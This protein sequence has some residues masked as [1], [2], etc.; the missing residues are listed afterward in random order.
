MIFFPRDVFSKTVASKNAAVFYCKYFVQ[1]SI[2]I[3]I[4]TVTQNAWSSN[5]AH[6]KLH[7]ST[8]K[9]NR[10]NHSIEVDSLVFKNMAPSPGDLLKQMIACLNKGD[11][12]KLYRLSITRQEYLQLYPFLPNADTTHSDD[13][14]FRMGF[15]LM[16]N[17]KMVLRAFSHFGAQALEF[18]R[19]AFEAQ[20]EDRGTLIFHHGLKVWVKKSGQE[21]EL[22]ISRSLI[23]THGGWK[24][25][26]F[27]S[28]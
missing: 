12:A 14:D 2:L 22:P 11:T 20:T 25:W 15:F 4:L 7:Q 13:K 23:F 18:S 1:I 9:K 26:G 21:I 19:F 5:P 16:D 3:L 10:E 27:S 8:T 17:R 28:D 24:F 6:S